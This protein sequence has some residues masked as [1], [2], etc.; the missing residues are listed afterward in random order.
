M[1][2]SALYHV[3]WTGRLGEF[4]Y[5]CRCFELCAHPP[6]TGK[7]PKDITDEK[8]AKNRTRLSGRRLFLKDRFDWNAS[9]QSF[10]LWQQA[11]EITRRDHHIIACSRHIYMGVVLRA[12]PVRG[13]SHIQRNAN[14]EVATAY[15]AWAPTGR[16]ERL[17]LFKKHP[18]RKLNASQGRGVTRLE[19]SLA[20]P[21]ANLRSWQ[22]MYCNEESTY[23]IVGTFQRPTQ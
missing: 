11:I 4:S 19:T 5:C 10:T 17:A 6:R 9:A 7:Q 18:T 22:H 2:P 20:L 8:Y 23:D 21:S 16:D 15:S 12:H 14:R 13:E 3:V 1:P